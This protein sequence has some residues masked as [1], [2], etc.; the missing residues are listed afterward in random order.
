M[1]RK[2][3]SSSMLTGSTI[4]PDGVLPSYSRLEAA[5][6]GTVFHDLVV[7][8]VDIGLCEASYIGVVDDGCG[9]ARTAHGKLTSA[10]RARLI[11]V[12]ARRTGSRSAWGHYGLYLTP[13]VS[14][15]HPDEE[16][17]LDGAATDRTLPA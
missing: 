1:S 11:T 12:P 16:P 5:N 7:R 14:S 2:L 8:Q 10:T 15:M 13:N 17:G 4:S 3:I 9:V 6:A